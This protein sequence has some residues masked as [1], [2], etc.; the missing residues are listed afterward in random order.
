MIGFCGRD[1]KGEWQAT[2][3]TVPTSETGYWSR[4]NLTSY[5]E[6]IAGWVKLSTIDKLKKVD[7]P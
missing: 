7:S 2:Q 6:N 1:G 4:E 3:H 5:D